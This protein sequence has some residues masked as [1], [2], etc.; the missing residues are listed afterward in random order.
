M[1]FTNT[2]A[3]STNKSFPVTVDGR[4]LYRNGDVSEQ[5]DLQIV[6]MYYDTV[7]QD[8]QNRQAIKRLVKRPGLKAS[9]Y[10]LTKVNPTDEVR[11]YFYDVDQNAFYWAVG[12]KLYAVNPDVGTSI[13][14][15]ATLNTSSGL[16]GF[17]SFLKSDNTRYVIASDGTDI[18]VDNYV[19]SSCARVTDA[20]L[21][22]PHEPSI[23]YLDGYLFLIKKDT[24]DIYNSDLDD[25]MSWTPGDF[26]T[27]EISSDYLL[28][29]VKAKNYIVALGYNSIEYFYD[30][31]NVSGSPLNR[32]DSPFRSVGYLSGLCTI[33]D[34]TYF[35]GQ[36]EKHNVG[37]YTIDSFD[38]KRISN[39]VVERTIQTYSSANNAKSRVQLNKPGYALSVNGHNFYV[40]PI[41]TTT[42]VYDIDEK[43][44]YEW[45]NA[46]GNGLNIEAAWGMYNGS[47]Y[48]AIGG[49]NYIS[50]LSPSVYQD[51]DTNFTCRY[52]S[53]LVDVETMNWKYCHR[54]HLECSQEGTTGTSNITLTW[55]DKDWKEAASASRT[56]NVFSISPQIHK[57]GRFRKRSFRLEY[58]DNY[59]FWLRGFVLDVSIGQI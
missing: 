52:T 21:P 25:P 23:I 1:A 51:F 40:V 10:D 49:H 56:I 41:S 54:L 39:S 14:A 46:S 19:A 44:W 9:S 13:R 28:R 47:M 42:W 31:G 3:Q 11:G 17:C 6:N 55:S 30:A 4:V 35:I 22:T 5:R 15:V 24:G 33:G 26:I 20:D 50:I 48:V 34:I 43:E 2:P 45:K 53:E 27:A 29:L 7:Y 16:V 37:V 12:N 57:L 18:W 36:D 32:N 38:V 58:S 8:S 59:P